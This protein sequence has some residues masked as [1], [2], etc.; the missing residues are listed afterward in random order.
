MNEKGTSSG[1]PLHFFLE[2]YEKAYEEETTEFIDCLI[3][4]KQPS[5]KIKDALESA[6]L[7]LAAIKSHKEN[8]TVKINEIRNDFKIGEK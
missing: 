7:S 2:R 4:K 6:L 3:N 5:V 1:N 8:R